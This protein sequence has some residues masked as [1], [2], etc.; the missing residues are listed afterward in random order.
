MSF[1][2][3]KPPLSGFTND[4]DGYSRAVGKMRPVK[5]AGPINVK[6]CPATACRSLKS[7]SSAHN[8]VSLKAAG[9]DHML[10]DVLTANLLRYISIC[11]CF[12]NFK[13]NQIL[14]AILLQS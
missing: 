2:Q 1:P 10:N 8:A 7:I 9:K 11:S 13:S 6:G 5:R 4:N 12:S 14:P 3:S